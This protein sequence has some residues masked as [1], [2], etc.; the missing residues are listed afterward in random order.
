[1]NNTYN[2]PKKDKHICDGCRH[3]NPEIDW[4]ETH[5]EQIKNKKVCEGD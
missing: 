4:C 3:F 1:M 2:K 5:N